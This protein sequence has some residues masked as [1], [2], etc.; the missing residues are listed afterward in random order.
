LRVSPDE[1]GAIAKKAG[2]CNL[3]LSDYLRRCALDRPVSSRVDQ[4]A[5]GELRRQ[6]GL[7]KHLAT[8]DKFHAYEYRRL[9]S[10]LQ[11]AANRIAR[12]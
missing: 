8:M 9:L 4:A 2:D 10:L 5:L 7:V 6:G 3:S 1:R 11:E 12:C